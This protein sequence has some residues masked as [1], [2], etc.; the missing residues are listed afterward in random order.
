MVTTIYFYLCLIVII[1][2]YNIKIY[3]S[4]IKHPFENNHWNS[5]GYVPRVFCPHGFSNLQGVLSSG[6]FVLDS[7]YVDTF[8]LLTVAPLKSFLSIASCYFIVDYPK[9]ADIYTLTMILS[10]K[11]MWQPR[12][13]AAI[14]LSSS[15]SIP[16]T[17][18][19]T[20]RTV[21]QGSCVRNSLSEKVYEVP[22]GSLISRNAWEKITLSDSEESDCEHYAGE[23]E[24]SLIIC[25]SRVMVRWHCY[26]HQ[27][28]IDIW[29]WCWYYLKNKHTK[30]DI[31]SWKILPIYPMTITCL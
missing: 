26:I 6:G 12:I 18:S 13:P 14:A 2:N 7:K 22:V 25:S 27:L 3:H 24:N 8:L 1:Q 17:G 31:L 10:F 4:H 29:F 28:I 11:K 16:E 21:I 20:V 15:W 19:H 30:I 23:M 9:T 5:G